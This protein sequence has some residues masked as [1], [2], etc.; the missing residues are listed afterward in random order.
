MRSI[1]NPTPI[2]FTHAFCAHFPP[3]QRRALEA[4]GA[5]IWDALCHSDNLGTSFEPS[6]ALPLV[7]TDLLVA[8]QQLQEFGELLSDNP[9]PENAPLLQLALECGRQVVAVA[10]PLKAALGRSP[11]LRLRQEMDFGAEELRELAE[12]LEQAEGALDP[13]TPE[14]EELASLVAF[15]VVQRIAPTIGDLLGLAQPNDD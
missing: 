5:G 15:I 4:A 13:S 10:E 9:P 14:Q 3:G 6:N 11:E 8:A 7:V 1:D 12:R 2:T